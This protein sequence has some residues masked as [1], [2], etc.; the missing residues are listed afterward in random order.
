[1]TN[2]RVIVYLN[3][4]CKNSNKRIFERLLCTGSADI[5]IDFDKLVY[6]LRLLFGSGCIVVFELS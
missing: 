5:K 3:D 4:D 1:M 6:S 2:F